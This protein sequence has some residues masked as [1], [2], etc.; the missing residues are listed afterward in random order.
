MA[1][2]TFSDDVSLLISLLR[3][4]GERFYDASIYR[5][6]RAL[7]ELNL[8]RMPRMLAF[9]MVGNRLI[10]RSMDVQPTLTDRPGLPFTLIVNRD[11]VLKPWHLHEGA[12]P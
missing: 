12:A 1:V 10:D 9:S 6:V 4:V 8:E 2:R 11:L 5:S 3:Q 7:G